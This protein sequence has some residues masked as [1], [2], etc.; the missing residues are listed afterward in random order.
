MPIIA[1]TVTRLKRL[2]TSLFNRAVHQIVVLYTTDVH[3]HLYPYDYIRGEESRVGLTRAATVIEQYRK[4]F[5][6]LILLDNGDF[7][8]G[9]P[10]TYYYNFIARETVHPVAR[11]MNALGYQAVSVGNHDIEQGPGVYLRVRKQMR[12][13]WLS[14]NAN[15]KPRGSYFQPYT[16]RDIEGI[17]I[18]ILGMT[19]PAIPL[20]LEPELYPG[21]TWQDMLS[22]TRSW[23]DY[24][25]TKK[26]ADVIIGLFHAGIHPNAGQPGWP[27]DL[28]EENPCLQIAGQI[29]ELDVILAAHEHRL[30]NSHPE[31]D[32]HRSINKPL[33]IMAGSH[34]RYIGVVQL[35]LKKQ[36]QH[37][38]VIDKWGRLERVAGQPAHPRILQLLRPYH[39]EVLH[40]VS[41]IIG[42]L[43]APLTARLSRLM[44][45]PL[46]DFIHQMQMHFTDAPL[47]LAASFDV[48]FQLKAGPIRIKDVYGV[49]KYENY[50]Y[51]VEMT[52]AQFLQ[53]LEWS[54]QYFNT[55]DPEHFIAEDFIN[56]HFMGFNFDTAEGVTYEI[57]VTR[58]VG[59]RIQNLRLQSTGEPL[60]P[61]QR[62]RVAVN[63]YRAQQLRQ[64][65]NCP[66]V[67]KSN[68]E[69]RDLMVEYIQSMGTIEPTCNHNWKIVP[70]WVIQ[71]FIK[72]RLSTE[73]VK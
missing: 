31:D 33:V 46:L 53:H 38:Q 52:G 45:T 2:Y 73:N 6:H 18:A 59:Q 54:T 55:V 17:R 67:W 10:M 4:Q 65:Y 57:N 36:D 41:S 8:Q 11:V 63:S 37:W 15:R 70:E 66:V 3:G 49:Y 44:D 16:I 60:R 7:L 20:W 47:S 42:H 58:P 13:P 39:R 27:R 29:P 56:H 50:L 51:V 19:T 30:Y 22:S 23:V 5:P 21:I 43:K 35:Q 26:Q 48:H 61:E 9:T 32:E 14:A 71:R 68:K 28:P 69:I 1:P 62:Y 34:A 12:F 72:Q 40:Y 64:R 25:K 24:L